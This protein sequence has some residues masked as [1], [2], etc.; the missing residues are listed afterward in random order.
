MN[1]Q[2]ALT[3]KVKELRKLYN[4]E[5]QPAL[6]NYYERELSKASMLA[7]QTRK[8]DSGYK[9]PRAMWAKCPDVKFEACN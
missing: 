7:D 9:S 6:K 5:S 4:K 3:Y 8:N 1:S 2:Q